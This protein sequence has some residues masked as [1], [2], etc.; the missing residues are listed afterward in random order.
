MTQS[1]HPTAP[2]LRELQRLF[3]APILAGA[4]DVPAALAN[5]LALPAGTVPA[6]RLAVHVEGYPARLG[7][8]LAEQ[9]PAVAHLVGGPRFAA[10]VDRY[11]RAARLQSYNLND[12]GAELPAF[13]ADDGLAGALPFLPDL[14]ALEWAMTRSFHAVAASIDP[15]LLAGDDAGAALARLAPAVAVV[16]SRWPIYALWSARATPREAIDIDLGVGESVLVCRDGDAV[17]CQLLTPP[18]LGG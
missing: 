12:A 6:E 9:F 14:A 3:A 1:S 2:S 13:L 11:Q 16:E 7:E 8:A 10:L 4:A 5:W 18:P 15:A 17:V